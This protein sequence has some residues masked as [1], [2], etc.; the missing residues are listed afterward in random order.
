MKGH[1]TL[2][3]L[4][5]TRSSVTPSYLSCFLILFQPVG[6]GRDC[7]ILVT[8]QCTHLAEE[9]EA[10]TYWAKLWK[11]GSS[12]GRSPME[13]EARFYLL[14]NLQPATCIKLLQ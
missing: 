12:E 2:L 10:S 14:S 6:R 7:S 5:G 3:R 13:E 9:K 4:I 11:E 1:G 8:S